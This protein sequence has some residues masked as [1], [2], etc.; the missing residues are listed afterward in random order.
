M[1]ANGLAKTS[2]VLIG[3]IFL[4]WTFAALVLA[5][6]YQLPFFYFNYLAF[7]NVLMFTENKIVSL[8]YTQLDKV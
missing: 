3:V 5:K 8:I 1:F 2:A 6:C 4:F 7:K